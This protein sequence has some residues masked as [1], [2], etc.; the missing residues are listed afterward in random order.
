MIK[1]ILKYGLFIISFILILIVGLLAYTQTSL[2]REQLR[3]KVLQL[4]N[5]LFNGDIDVGQ[6]NGNLYQTIHLSDVSLIEGDSTVANIDSLYVKYQLIDLKDKHIRIDTLYIHSLHFN[7]WYKD[8][9]K[10]HLM[11]VLDKLVK[12]ERT[13][14]PF[15]PVIL[16][17][18]YIEIVDGAGKYQMKYGAEPIQFSDFE[19]SA[20]AFFKNKHV[21]VDLHHLHTSAKS[22]D[23]NLEN[24]SV[25]FKK[26]GRYME[27]DSLMLKTNHSQ[28]VGSGSYSNRGDY[29]VN[30]QAEPIAS[31]DI[32]SVYSGIGIKTIPDLRVRVGKEGTAL[33]TS[34]YAFNGSKSLG[35]KGIVYDLTQVLAGE[36]NQ[37]KYE[38]VLAFNQFVPEEWID[39]KRTGAYLNGSLDIVGD[40]I[41]DY[42]DD[43]R[44]EARFNNSSYNG[45]VTDTLHF[46]A[47]QANNVVDA[48]VLLVYNQSRSNGELVINDLY[49]V[50]I[51]TADF[52]T[53]NLDLEAIE[54]RLENT[55]VNGQIS[56]SGTRIL[57]GNRQFQTKANLNNGTIYNVGFD[58]LLVQGRLNNGLLQLDTLGIITSDHNA[59]S[60]GEYHLKTKRFE[61]E[62]VVQS[63]SFPFLSGM[64]IPDIDFDHSL[65]D[66]KVKGTAKDFDYSANVFLYD[67]NAIG[68]YSDTLYGEVE[69]RFKPDSI[70]SFGTIGLN[71]LLNPVQE[72]DTVSINYS[73][74]Q[75]RLNTQ[76]L[77]SREDTLDGMI[78]TELA[79]GDTLVAKVYRGQIDLPFAR[80]YMLD[81]AKQIL[82]HDNFI[83]FNHFTFNDSLD[84]N[85]KFE[86][87]GLLSMRDSADFTL[88]VNHLNLYLFNKFIANADTVSGKV[89]ADFALSG[90]PGAYFLNGSY[91]I[92][93]PHYGVAALPSIDGELFF[94]NDTFLANGWLPD[95]DSSLYFNGAV[96]LFLDV[97]EEGEFDFKGPETFKAEVEIDSLAFELPEIEE[98]R[99][100][101]ANGVFNGTLEANGTFSKP[102]FFGQVKI[103]DGR[104]T[105]QKQGI[106][107][108]EMFGQV[109]FMD[110]KVF[111][112]T[113]KISTEDGYFASDGYIEF[114]STL[115]SGKLI[116]TDIKSDIKNFHAI[117]H[118]NSDINISGNPYY[119]SEE[120]EDPLF[121]GRITVNRSVFN[122][123]DL[124]K[125]DEQAQYDE[126]EPL[127]LVAI[128]QNDS[129]YMLAEEI[130][131]KEKSAFMKELKGRLRID[132]PRSAW[133]KGDDMN[134]EI[135]GD[136]DIAKTT[137]YFELFGDVEVV[138]G[139]YILY[140]RKFNIDVGVITFMG[141]EKPDP[142]LDI[143]ASYTFRG[144]DKEKH[145]LTLSVTEYLSE[146]RILFYLDDNP[147]SQSDAVSIMIFGKTMDE[148]SYD[149]QNGI[150]GSVG[151]NVL[152]NVITSSLSSTIGQRFK[153][154]M[155][156]VNS[157]EN[158]QSAA[159]VVG[160]YIT[161][162]LFVIYQRGFGET[163]D[164][165]ITP[166]TI[167]LE[168]EL[169]KVLFFRL[170]SG[171]SKTSGFDVILK[172]ESDK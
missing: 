62:A 152:A 49:N 156:E 33:N 107:Y 36:L 68:L 166:E 34:L 5:P 82:I 146:P 67:V 6:I 79:F 90:S 84:D 60:S 26:M 39:I 78:D 15:F 96:P 81:T 171:S 121:G 157:T 8:T 135:A 57:S 169:N 163:E 137:D 101:E 4:T 155:I 127:L 139:H 9:A 165:E 118:K 40:D 164:D 133:L 130:E 23:V 52:I 29:H 102:Q 104:L 20:D 92:M 103:E 17:F 38:A 32:S 87:D 45:T 37:I 112:D 25:R 88:D 109:S 58:S 10:M 75:D 129:S 24:V 74:G 105:D 142:R 13:K 86:L 115:I 162:D 85:F 123:S 97:N 136:L 132:I 65:I 111:V 53:Q 21:E 48:S 91:N 114:D 80:F 124:I 161:N 83:E 73:Y 76:V 110:N 99:H 151:S 168:Y 55:V 51:Y 59:V 95:L 147:I 56:I 160:K 149:G 7:L 117:Q 44:I 61:V 98:Y 141:G 3:V 42:K 167:T 41:L 159:F 116:A 77:F 71:N 145:E 158:W 31:N 148:L 143:S 18:G 120:G 126:N 70:S 134:I 72:L 153:L 119:K 1:K 93:N 108:N 144:S 43:L 28:L 140:G 35:L 50:P 170:Q 128:H 27:F 138:R 64:D 54:P 100:L 172:F 89:S 46:D 19:L 131:E 150:I 94:E 154:D 47:I 11:Y 113:V 122:L 66:A 125:T 30:I 22:P 63:K 69:G 16:D 14:T 106:Y 12:K 2:F